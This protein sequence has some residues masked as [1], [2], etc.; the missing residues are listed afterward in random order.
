MCSLSYDKRFRVC[1]GAVY[2]Q[3]D[4]VDTFWHI[5]NRDGQCSIGLVERIGLSDGIGYVSDGDIG[6][7]V[8]RQLIGYYSQ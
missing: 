1:H 3:R 7:L 5:V 4:I 2:V 6:A 8:L